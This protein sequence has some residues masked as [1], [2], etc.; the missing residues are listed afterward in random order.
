MVCAYI[1]L[2]RGYL[3]DFGK[4]GCLDSRKM[5]SNNG[6]AIYWIPERCLSSIGN[7]E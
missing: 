2:R 6:L 3:F 7:D 4:G 1:L 5:L